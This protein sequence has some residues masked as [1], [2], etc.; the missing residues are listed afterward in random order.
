VFLAWAVAFATPPIRSLEGDAALPSGDS[1]KGQGPASTGAAGKTAAKTPT[2]VMRIP[3]EGDKLVSHTE[4][5]KRFGRLERNEVW[6]KLEV[7]AN[8]AVNKKPSE[9]IQRLGYWFLARAAGRRYRLGEFRSEE[10]SK[11]PDVL[12]DLAMENL[13]K[14]V[15][16]GFRN[17]QAI[18]DAKELLPLRGVAAFDALLEALQK[19][20]FEKLVEDYQKGVDRGLEGAKQLP[21][22]P[23]KPNL[24][25]LGD[26]DPRPEGKP[27]LIVVTR[28][29]HDGFRKLLDPLKKIAQQHGASLPIGVAFYQH[30]LDDTDRENQTRKYIAQNDEPFPVSFPCA[31]M[32]HEEFRRLNDL[33]LER[34]AKAEEA[35]GV[36]KPASLDI[37][38]PICIFL[39]TDGTPLFH[40]S[41]VLDDWQA[42]YVVEQFLASVGSNPA[43]PGEGAT[44]P[45]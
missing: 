27:A 18:D 1:P 10:E 32:D 30:R 39:G 19:E 36:K 26:A 25:L 28:I 16:L 2:G 21:P 34:H 35:A 11:T 22:A 4:V 6:D 3:W 42:K 40:T 44:P 29:H 12:R 33:L 45:R 5:I 24:K 43:P 37:F 15:D 31:L 7:L 13:K 23:W 38:Q 17:P 41:G 20:T 8:E 14:A 9:E